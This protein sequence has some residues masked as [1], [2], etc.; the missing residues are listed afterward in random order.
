[1]ENIL[2]DLDYVVEGDIVA[3]ML[4]VIVNALLRSTYTVKKAN[5][6]LFRTANRLVG[7]A[8]VTSITYHTLLNYISEST[9]PFIYVYRITTYIALIWTYICFCAYI[10]NLVEMSKKYEFLDKSVNI[11]EAVYYTKGV[12][13]EQIQKM[14][15]HKYP[16]S[17]IK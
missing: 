7:V 10:K 9:V 2:F 17:G 5:I 3:L 6:K 14:K 12:L 16:V 4:C 13:S 11:D 15:I 1:M 8:A